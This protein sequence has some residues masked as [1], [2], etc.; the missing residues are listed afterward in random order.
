MI[1]GMLL[2]LFITCGTLL[3]NVEVSESFVVYVVT[4]NALISDGH[5][6]FV[7]F[8]YIE[9]FLLHTITIIVLKNKYDYR[10]NILMQQK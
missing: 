3:L 4:E 7:S 5:R 8:F 9:T 2:Y 10:L 6:L 1:F